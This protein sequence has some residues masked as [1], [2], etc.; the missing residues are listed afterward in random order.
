MV[1]DH[2]QISLI[3][4][5]SDKMPR[6]A[7]SVKIPI[8]KFLLKG[9]ITLQK[10]WVPN[11]CHNNLAWLLGIKRCRESTEV[12]IN[13]IKC[14][15]Q[16]HCASEFLLVSLTSVVLCSFQNHSIRSVRACAV[17]LLKERLRAVICF[18]LMS[19]PKNYPTTTR[20]KFLQIK[21]KTHCADRENV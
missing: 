21:N 9:K 1:S 11:V 6:R 3:T 19:G 18:G 4:L 5:G 12:D 17:C 2:W 10:I 13:W 16:I 20:G 8:T 7:L 14:S 15:K